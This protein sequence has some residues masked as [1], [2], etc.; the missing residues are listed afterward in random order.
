MQIMVAKAIHDEVLTDTPALQTIHDTIDPELVAWAESAT[1]TLSPEYCCNGDSMHHVVKGVIAIRVEDTRGFEISRN[2]IQNVENLSFPAFKECAMFHPG[3]SE[4]N[5]V[6]RQLGDVRAISAAA[7]RGYDDTLYSN[8]A[9]NIIRQVSSLHG[10]YVIGIDIQG[11]SEGV[12][13]NRNDVDLLADMGIDRDDYIAV[14]VRENA[15]GQTIKVGKD[16]VLRQGLKEL[17]PKNSLR[18][19]NFNHPYIPD[20]EWKNGGCPYARVPGRR[21]DDP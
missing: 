3:S 13:V 14:R 11:E 8:I 15:D 10:D 2:T 5:G 21:I 18:K 12:N 17:A 7:A 9:D 20:I 19:R 1:A 16:N 6:L 4:E